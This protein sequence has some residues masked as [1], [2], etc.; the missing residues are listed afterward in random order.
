MDNCIWQLLN[1]V[2]QSKIF[3][4]L[5][6]KCFLKT[7]DNLKFLTSPCPLLGKE[8]VWGVG[9]F[10]FYKFKKRLSSLIDNLIRGVGQ[11]RT[12]E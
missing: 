2:M 5:N 8:G 10:S 7:F 3:R 9:H 11:I 4:F 12:D 6:Q 1:E